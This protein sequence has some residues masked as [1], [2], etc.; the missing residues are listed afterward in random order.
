VSDTSSLRAE[1]LVAASA[2]KQQWRDVPRAL[3]VLVQT[4]TDVGVARRSRNH[5]LSSS[6]DAASRLTVQIAQDRE[7]V[8]RLLLLDQSGS[9]TRTSWAGLFQID[10]GDA[11]H[12][13]RI[14]PDASHLIRMRSMVAARG[15]SG[16]S[17]LP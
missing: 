6:L 5:R 13:I 9:E 8:A 7:A 17:S 10:G 12:G 1:R 14:T 2:A 4:S 11:S 15:G 3:L 16:I